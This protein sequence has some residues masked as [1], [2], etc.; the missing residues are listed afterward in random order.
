MTRPALRH[1]LPRLSAWV[2]WLA[3]LL[4]LAQLAAAMHAYVHLPDPVRVS[5]DK[6]L[7]APCDVCVLAAALGSAAPGGT[8]AGQ[9]QL[10]LEQP[11]PQA[12]PA[13]RPDLAAP[14]HYR[15]RAPPALPA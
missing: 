8:P 3:L 11:A 7:P 5:S 12:V 15:S 2:L 9:P 6:H 14:S 4:P 1:R 10:A 13:S